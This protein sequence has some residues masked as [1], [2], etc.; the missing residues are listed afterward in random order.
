MHLQTSPIR[1]IHFLAVAFA[2]FWAPAPSALAAGVN[3][4]TQ[5]E[6]A[7]GWIKLFDGQTLFGWK[8]ANEADWKVEEGA[9]VVTTGD[10]G[11]LH[12]TTQFADYTLKVDFRS[13]PGTNSG[14]FLHTP[15][16]PG[17][18][19]SDCYELNIAPPD[20]PFPTGSFV[21]RQKV[22]GNHESD[23]WQSYEVT[24]R[25]GECQVNLDGETV[26][27][28][29]DPDPLRRG[30]IGLQLNSGKVQF[31]NI[32]L[33]PLATESIFNDSDVT[34]WKIDQARES[35]FTAEDGVLRVRNGPGQIESEGEYADFILQLDVLV[36]GEHLNSGIFF[37]SIP[38]DFQNGYES[39][40]HNGFR[41]GDPT[42]PID[43]GTGAIFRRQSARRVVPR[44]FE[45]FH[46]TIVADGPHMA[47]WVNGYQVTDW[48]D[49]RQPDENPR[50][51]QRLKAGTLIIQGHD[52]TTD[53]SFRNMRIAELP[54][55][56][57]P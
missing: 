2:V 44:D 49:T 8:A 38:G 27:E 40:I 18:P 45:W 4:L 51:G 33:K 35:E 28:Y 22:E 57:E 3:E 9:I 10:Q 30:Y 26:L 31:R 25:G 5:E 42:Q 47:V 34:G 48:T 17:D 21:G 37:R 13:A 14:I 29:T 16:V 43:A 53:L 19:A 54:E 56:Q 55:R 15:P 7:E 11:L 41:D 36:N 12:T 1:A 46:K 39:Q 32:K 20:N 50:R 6:L 52:P 23:Q 24:L